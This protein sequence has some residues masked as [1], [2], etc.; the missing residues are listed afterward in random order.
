MI[1]PSQAE[2]IERQLINLARSG[3]LTRK[4]GD[5]ELRSMLEQVSV[6]GVLTVF[7]LHSLIRGTSP[8]ALLSLAMYAGWEMV[9]IVL[10]TKTHSTI[11]R[12]A[13]LSDQVTRR[14][15]HSTYRFLSVPLD[16]LSR[17]LRL[18]EILVGGMIW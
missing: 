7:H 12:P 1:R 3:Q 14:G 9:A 10:A 8:V 11:R 6:V 13:Q 18:P 16:P 2:A 4:L 17:Y 15:N 5:D